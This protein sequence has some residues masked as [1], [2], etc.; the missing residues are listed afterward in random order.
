MEGA[1]YRV[2][3]AGDHAG[4]QSHPPGAFAWQLSLAQPVTGRRVGVRFPLVTQE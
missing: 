3:T 4:D 2:V 1:Y